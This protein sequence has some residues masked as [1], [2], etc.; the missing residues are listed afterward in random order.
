METVLTRTADGVMTATLNRPHVLNAFNGAATD[1]LTRV[2]AGAEE[3][4]DIS[5]LVITGAGR[6]FSSGYDLAAP[7]DRDREFGSAALIK[8]LAAFR[9]PLI[10]AVNGIAVGLGASMTS[11]ADITVVAHSARLRYPFVGMGLPPEAGST[12]QL[13]RQIG[14]QRAFWYLTSGVWVDSAECV[15]AGLALERVPDRQ[16]VARATEMAIALARQSPDAL[17]ETKQLMNGPHRDPLIASIR[18]ENAAVMRL[19]DAPMY[20]ES[21]AAFRANRAADLSPEN[22]AT[23]ETTTESPR[24]DELSAGSESHD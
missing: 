24:A 14:R 22:L 23:Y 21:V 12:Y 11:L 17:I 9:K 16:L 3:D 19:Q 7:P 1:R 13:P 20:R 18:A 4:D 10:L 5:V 6:A 15:E 2:V 8:R